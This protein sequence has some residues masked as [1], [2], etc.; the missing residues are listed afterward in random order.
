MQDK[1]VLDGPQL[2][3]KARITPA[4]KTLIW[5]RYIGPGLNKASCPLCNMYELQRNANSGFEA[6][7]II[8]SRW[9]AEDKLTVYY[10]VPSCAA[11]N[12]ECNDACLLDYLYCRGRMN[13]LRHLIRCIYAAYTE[14]NPNETHN[15]VHIMSRL[16]GP[17]RF[18]AGGGLVNT[19]EIY[20][21]ALAEQTTLLTRQLQ[22]LTQK[23]QETSAELVALTCTCTWQTH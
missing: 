13:A 8:A 11:C 21:I 7:H 12:N 15:I 16:Y 19:T 3:K 4:L 22:T 23:L 10:A 2:T 20:N 1:G 18:K 5:A 6:A 14:E 17:A 9:Y